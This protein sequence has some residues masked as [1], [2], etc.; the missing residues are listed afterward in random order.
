MKHPPETAVVSGGQRPS[1]LLGRQRALSR[2]VGA[3]A[4]PASRSEPAL[5]VNLVSATEGSVCEQVRHVGGLVMQSST[6]QMVLLALAVCVAEC[7]HDHVREYS[8]DSPLSDNRTM[9]L[10]HK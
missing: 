8:H 3:A 1:C 10:H 5:V 7:G 4:L 2:L 6:E 9:L